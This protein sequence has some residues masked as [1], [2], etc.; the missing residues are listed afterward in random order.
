MREMIG[1]NSEDS[2]ELYYLILLSEIEHYGQSSLPES[3]FWH[4]I[5]SGIGLQSRNNISFYCLVEQGNE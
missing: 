1:T 5:Q 2:D 3:Q 4:D